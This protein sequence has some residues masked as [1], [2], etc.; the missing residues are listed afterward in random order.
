[1]RG[2]LREEAP[3]VRRSDLRQRGDALRAQEFEARAHVALVR[4]V[5]EVCEAALHAAEDDEVG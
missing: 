2:L 1:M 5:R 3:Q 4:L